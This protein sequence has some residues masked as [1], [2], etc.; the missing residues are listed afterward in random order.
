MYINGNPCNLGGAAFDGIA[1]FADPYQDMVSQIMPTSVASM[2]RHAE[3]LAVAGD[4]TLREAF[5]RI[6]AYFLTEV[7]VTGDLGEDESENQRAYLYD[8]MRIMSFL[9]EA[10]LSCLVYGNFYLS[11]MMPFTRYLG[12]PQCGAT[13]RFMDFQEDPE[14]EFQWNAAFHGTC[15][16]CKFN[17][18][19]GDPRDEPDDSRPLILR[20]WNPH[21]IRIV[22]NEATGQSAAFDWIMPAD[23]RSEIRLGQNRYV[24]ADTPW[25]WIRAGL[26]EMNVRMNPDYLYH[27]REP[28][29]AGLR[30]RGMGVPRAIVNLRRTYFTQIL[31]RMNEV[32]AIG[33][34]VPLRVVSPANTSSRDGSGI[35][36]IVQTMGMGDLK[37]Q[38][39]RMQ[40]LHRQDPNSIHYSPVPLQMQALGADARQLI[41]ADI[42]NQ[43]IEMELNACGIPV[44]F[45]RASMQIQAAPVALRLMARFWAPHV[46]G[47]NGC[48]AHIARRAQFLK[49]WEA[50]KYKLTETTVVDDI[51]FRQ[52]VIQ[53]AQAGLVSRDDALKQI[54]T[55][56]REQTRKKFQDLR[57]EADETDKFQQTQDA[58]A[59]SR[60]LSQVT[61]GGGQPTGAP[62][63]AQPGAGPAGD[64]TSPGGSAGSGPPPPGPGGAAPGGAPGAAPQGTDP[65]AGVIPQPGQKIDPEDLYSRAQTAA[66]TLLAQP[67]SQR[68]GMLRNIDQANPMFHK[69]V[70]Q[71]MD[72]TRSKNRSAGG[73]Q[74]MQQQFG[75]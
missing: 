70:R 45:Y 15:K 63:G 14:C 35:G 4:G 9:V 7:V 43:A 21:D 31:L 5:N 25:D 12:C 28:A 22:Y 60:Q 16:A 6:A 48:L 23:I 61:P 18:D 17:G 39:M 36:D 62:P 8:D 59:F 44:D 10:G 47:L 55:S 49:R 13:Y 24:L 53:M 71:L 74:M 64:P 37:V 51:E 50:A 3:W 2:L 54:H 66:N 30:F 68:F 57:T 42:T 11:V 1:P 56:L 40:A 19:F 52:L 34:V 46:D 58:F 41:P 26:A 20:A 72:E 29:L 67:E 65:L 73:R 32:L 38:F 33:H 27:W 69:L 75:Q